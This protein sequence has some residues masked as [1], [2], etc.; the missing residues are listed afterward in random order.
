M[1]QT[2]EDKVLK[3]L[4]G[5][6]FQPLSPIASNMFL[7]NH[8]G[9]H[10]AGIVLKDPIKAFEI[11]REI[12]EVKDLLAKLPIFYGIGSPEGVIRAN[13]GSIYLN[14]SGGSSTTLYVKESGEDDKSG[15]IGK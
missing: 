15:W 9:D 1:G 10:S 12:K 2:R 13:K 6:Q 3:Q 11:N 7:P 14:L 5:E 4:S 8:S